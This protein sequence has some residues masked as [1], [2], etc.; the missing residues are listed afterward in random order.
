MA[1][2]PERIDGWPALMS[3]EVAT[4]YLS[5]SEDALL[6]LACRLAIP[7]VRLDETQTRWKKQDLDGLIRRLP[8]E[9]IVSTSP[10]AH[11][12]LRLETSQ[13]EAIAEAIIARLGK[14]VSAGESKLVSIKEAG[15]YLGIGRSSVYRL[16]GEKRLA[17]KHIG[18]RTLV[19]R[20][21]IDAILSET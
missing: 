5:M 18:R 17:T 9:P 3:T 21:S 15:L 16:I 2:T 6:D 20:E 19:C 12:V 4:R 13:V 14:Q 11:R 10:P 1:Q 8:K 7:V